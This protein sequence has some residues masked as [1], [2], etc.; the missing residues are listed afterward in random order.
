MLA[1]DEMTE[2]KKAR[3]G[4]DDLTREQLVLELI[5]ARCKIIFLRED[6]AIY[7][8]AVKLLRKELG[9]R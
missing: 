1:H 6:L 9:I 8:D 3:Q 5:S 7:K 2:L 4:L